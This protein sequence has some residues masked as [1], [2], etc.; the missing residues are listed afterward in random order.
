V[1]FA[2]RTAVLWVV[3]Y[4]VLGLFGDFDGAAVAQSLILA[5]AISGGIELAERRRGTPP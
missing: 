3:I 2:L 1:T 5:L 4:V